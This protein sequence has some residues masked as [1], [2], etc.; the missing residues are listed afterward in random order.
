MNLQLNLAEDG[1]VMEIPVV[2]QEGGITPCYTGG[3]Q[4]SKGQ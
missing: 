2:P 4:L 1:M 3:R